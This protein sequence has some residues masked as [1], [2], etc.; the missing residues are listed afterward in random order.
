MSFRKSS[1]FAALCLQ[2]LQHL[3]L[4]LLLLPLLLGVAV[5]VVVLLLEPVECLVLEPVV[6]VVVVV[7]VLVDLPVSPRSVLLVPPILVLVVLLCHPALPVDLR[8]PFIALASLNGHP[9]PLVAPRP[10]FLH[11]LRRLPPPRLCH[12]LARQ[13]HR[14]RRLPQRHRLPLRETQTLLRPLVARAPCR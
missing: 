2:Q 13:Q 14:R 5:G 11:V 8:C 3:P 6:V 10:P 4:A 9:Q 12:L 1:L 7:V